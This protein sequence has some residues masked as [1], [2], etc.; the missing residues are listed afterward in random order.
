M[1]LVIGDPD[2]FFYKFSKNIV[3]KIRTLF[4]RNGSFTCKSNK[5]RR[6]INVSFDH[7]YSDTISK[8]LHTRLCKFLLVVHRKSTNF[9]VL[10][11]L[12]RFPL[13]FDIVKS[14]IKY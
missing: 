5:F 10:S 11:E 12:G 6:G 4:A 13:H 8:K 9:A 2:V 3:T 7:I 1:T 14:I